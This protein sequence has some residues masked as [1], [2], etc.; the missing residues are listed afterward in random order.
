MADLFPLEMMRTAPELGWWCELA[1][2]PEW[3]VVYTSVVWQYQSHSSRLLSTL[4]V[5]DSGSK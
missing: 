5:R 4:Q 2:G 3:T 1:G